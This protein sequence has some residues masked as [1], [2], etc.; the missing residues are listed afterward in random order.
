[1]KE[2]NDQKIAQET[3]TLSA[4][5]AQVTSVQPSQEV[6]T[7]EKHYDQLHP[8]PMTLQ[9]LLPAQSQ[10]PQSKATEELAHAQEQQMSGDPSDEHDLLFTAIDRGVFAIA[11]GADWFSN[12][13]KKG[14]NTVSKTDISAV[15][16]KA[17]EKSKKLID[18]VAKNQF[19]EKSVK[20][21]EEVA[22]QTLDAL[23]AMGEKA[24][25]I[26]TKEIGPADKPKLRPRFVQESEFE[27][28]PQR[29]QVPLTFDSAFEKNLGAAHLQA[30]EFLSIECMMKTQQFYRQL[31]HDQREFVDKQFVTLQK[32]FDGQKEDIAKAL[33]VPATDLNELVEPQR[34]LLESKVSLSKQRVQS[35]TE[36]YKN[37]LQQ[38]TQLGINQTEFEEIS[39]LAI[40]FQQ[41][42]QFECMDRLAELSSLLVECL[43][44]IAQFL[45]ATDKT[46]TNVTSSPLKQSPSP[47]ATSSAPIPLATATT[48][49]ATT[50]PVT[51]PIS[52]NNND[53]ISDVNTSPT[54]TT[55]IVPQS[56]IQTKEC[57]KSVEELN[58]ISAAVYTLC[59]WLSEEM[60]K[61]STL[62]IDE[63]KEIT[64]LAKT[65]VSKED[66]R[67]FVDSKLNKC[68]NN[69]YLDTGIAISNI[70]EAKKF[71]FSVCKYVAT[72]MLK[73]S[74][75][76]LRQTKEPKNDEAS[77]M[78][79]YSTTTATAV[80]SPSTA[81]SVPVLSPSGPTTASTTNVTTLLPACT[82][83]STSTSTSTTKSPP[84]QI[85]T[86]KPI[87]K[88][89]A[90]S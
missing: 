60:T 74:H 59:E 38:L 37:G 5:S 6:Q 25:H 15:A 29:S 66:L 51:A 64:Q 27:T 81:T 89:T 54:S 57:I 4:Q 67:T 58:D 43:L 9:P 52:A 49:S 23:E 12:L 22:T 75:E 1:V 10:S 3:S 83:T 65:V 50:S 76:R 87:Q 41:K 44:H 16:N 47:A 11:S 7:T 48:Q 56:G 19:V 17:M 63:M 46:A 84:T 69:V 73:T 30:L 34:E 88:D 35:L 61:V 62:Y 79:S 72:I 26:F 68:T 86:P 39:G 36:E 82:P 33:L 24:L 42:L 14:V 80:T 55:T 78:P 31:K 21:G 20:V 2:A 8:N 18:S 70:Q 53:S 85:V 77:A 32:L 28:S 71:L 90:K 45:L 40:S 13:V